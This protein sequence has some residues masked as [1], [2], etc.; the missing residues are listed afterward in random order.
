[1]KSSKEQSSNKPLPAPTAPHPI[2]AVINPFSDTSTLAVPPNDP[3]K[4]IAINVGNS[5]THWSLNHSKKNKQ[6]L[7]WHTPHLHESQ[8]Y[9]EG[10]FDV[11]YLIK[12]LA[13]QNFQDDWKILKEMRIYVV[14]VV[15][16]EV[17]KGG[18]GGGGGDKLGEI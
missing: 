5:R 4:Y 2:P 8:L 17:S 6:I 13:V 18:G 11:Q 9:Q 7:A 3:G 12:Y 1:M 14:S 16:A 10:K 15:E